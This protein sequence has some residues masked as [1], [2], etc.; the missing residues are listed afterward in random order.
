MNGKLRTLATASAL[1]LAATGLLPTTNAGAG[2]ARCP[3]LKVSDG[4]YGDNEARIEALL[5]DHCHDKGGRKPVAVFDW[6]NTVVK[7]DVGDATF[8]WLLRHDRVRPPK[9][10][11]W[12]TTS[13]HLTPEA[14]TALGR[15]CPTGVR[16]LPTATDTRCADELLSVYADGATTT[17]RTAFAGHDHRRTEPRYAWLAQLLHGWTP[18]QAASF[19][20]AAR[21]EN[22]A[23]PQGAT[24]RV[25]TARVTGWV[26]YYD[27]QRDLIRAL[28]EGGFDVW[29][30][31]ASP[32]PVVDVWAKGVGIDPAHAVG[33]R[34]TTDHGRLTSH[35]KGCGTVR[36]GEDT[37]ITYIDG[38]RCWI[39]QE[40][41][42][43][44]GPDAERV[45]PADR[46][47]VFAAGDSDTD[48][49]FLRDATGL[50]LVLNRNKDELMC[51]AYEN[52]DGRWLVNPMFI[53]P[54]KRRTAPYPC[55]TTG[56]TAGDGTAQPVRR[57]DGSIVPDQ[58]DTVF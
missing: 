20:A 30:V 56:Y 39:N 5:A 49:S 27:Q 33:I 28:R 11:D 10:G 50:R 7:N 23:A 3:T 43:V 16:T 26:R 18:R 21:A 8:S 9:D 44:R 22:L 19:A 24:Q 25:G 17:G 1:A 42:G 55:A 51:R 12:S 6:D 57:P 52:G 35:L 13:R 45:R 4:W 53:E 48:V 32:E 36:D 41:F 46:R 54:K 15:A 31:S 2:P 37:M 14:A 34:N 40:V 29:I 58:P 47:Q 38:K